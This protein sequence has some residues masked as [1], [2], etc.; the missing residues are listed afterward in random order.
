MSNKVY[1]AVSLDGYIADKND[2]VEWLSIVPNRDE[3]LIDFTNFMDS[4]DCLVMGKNTFEIVKSF[5]EWIYDK[6]VFVVSSSMTSV[7]D[8]YEDKIELISG[9][10]SDI[11][12]SLHSR[13][14]ND[15]YID[16]GKT[17]QNF[18]EYDLIDEMIISI[19]P[20][21][22]GGGKRLFGDLKSSKE[23]ELIGTKIL[24]DMM[25]QIHYKRKGI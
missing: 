22:L 14:Y 12:S 2:S 15:L 23:F 21:L 25:V 16:G 18:L 6:K 9:L 4:I 8:G 13:G 20:T 5:G 1:I 19:V 17:I 7:P 11:I 24:S 10:P 3:N